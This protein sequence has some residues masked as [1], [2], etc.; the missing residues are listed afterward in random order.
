MSVSTILGL[1]FIAVVVIFCA[2]SGIELN[3]DEINR[4]RFNTWR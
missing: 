1:V 3:Q 2:R 4:D